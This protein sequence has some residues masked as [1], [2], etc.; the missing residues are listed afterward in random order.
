M[1]SCAMM[2]SLCLLLA[3][4]SG[5]SQMVTRSAVVDFH[6]SQ[7]QA[8]TF[9]G[10]TAWK[11]D[12]TGICQDRSGLDTIAAIAYSKQKD[13]VYVAIEC[14]N[15][16]EKNSS[17]IL[18]ALASAGTVQW[19]SHMAC[20][21]PAS[22]QNACF[23]ELLVADSGT[24]YLALQGQTRMSTQKA[25]GK[26]FAL[27]LD[28]ALLW[29][30]PIASDG[31]NDDGRFALTL[32]K[33]SSQGLV[34]VPGQDGKSLTALAAS[35]GSIKWSLPLPS[36]SRIVQ[37][38]V[39]SEGIFLALSQF[40]STSGGPNQTHGC[41]LTAYSKDGHSM[42]SH[43][44]WNK[45]G[46][47]GW[48]AKISMYVSSDSTVYVDVSPQFFKSQ[49]LAFSASGQKT[50]SLPQVGLPSNQNSKGNIVVTSYNSTRSVMSLFSIKPG[51][52][53]SL[54]TSWHDKSQRFQQRD[55]PGRPLLMQ[56]GSVYLADPNPQSEQ[57]ETGV[58]RV[59]N[60]KGLEKL[61]V[62]STLD[63]QP[64]A[65]SDGTVYIK[66]CHY[67]MFGCSV[68]SLLAI[69]AKA[70]SPKWEYVFNTT[71]LLSTLMV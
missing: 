62:N 48:L 69:D 3:F 38:D 14:V 11:H 53:V 8:V 23:S 26:I 63:F 55:F 12:F 13:A 71:A 25:S 56:D 65:A 35:D 47:D 39:A 29:S 32:G 4:W 66:R 46:S 49:L 24:V 60:A 54:F 9:D 19:K 5:T 16:M 21:S 15:S 37:A 61:I 22:T 36:A 33:G 27:T 2:R 68:F 41:Y 40:G 17:V 6:E 59:F 31:H 64:I 67:Y 45:S 57:D 58:L 20:P 10:L 50:W 1:L 28:G 43:T 34:L 30:A 52:S 42:W 18:A 44:L 7:M 51:G 70:T